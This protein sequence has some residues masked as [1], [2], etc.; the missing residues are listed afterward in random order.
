MDVSNGN[1]DSLLNASFA[2]DDFGGAAISSDATAGSMLSQTLA[3]VTLD[4]TGAAGPGA[5]SG[6]GETIRIA[7]INDT[8]NTL[9][10]VLSVGG[11]S[12]GQ[13]NEFVLGYSANAILVS[14]NNSQTLATL[15]NSGNNVDDVIGVISPS[16]VMSGTNIS[17][18]SSGTFS[19]SLPCF[20]AGTH[21][22]TEAGDVAVE[23]LREGDMLRSVL[24][25][26][27][28]PIRWIGRRTVA[29]AGYFH[30][31]DV[32]PVRICKN[33]FG[34]GKPHRDLFLSPDHAVFVNE[35]SIP[36]R[37][38]INGR[39][40]W[41]EMPTRVTYFHVELDDHDVLIAEGLPVEFCTPEHRQPRQIPRTA[42]Q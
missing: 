22:A 17:F 5:V 19:G 10:F 16:P 12:V 20:A 32:A 37:Y 34:T 30:P 25:G 24:S 27:V 13:L 7:A 31:E 38:L 4:T 41:Q 33:A 3:T 6:T 8:T 9:T 2:V 15:L 28:V 21:I 36:T 18:N 42:A 35:T 11:T 1:L 40:I 14:G 26:G 39:T 23:R 29:V